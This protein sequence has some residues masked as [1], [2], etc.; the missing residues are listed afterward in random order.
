MEREQIEYYRHRAGEYDDFWTRSGQYTLASD[1][2]ARWNADAAEAVAAVRS[3]APAGDVL[4]LACGTGLW[5][6][7]LASIA[8]SL[9]AV[10]SS[11]EML[12]LNA[13]RLA[14]GG[15]AQNAVTYEQADLFT[16]SPPA[17]CFDAVFFGYWHSH[18]PDERLA[19]FWATVG[20]ALQPGGSV[21]LV[22]SAPDPAAP[23]G[24]LA[25]RDEQRSLKDGRRYRVVKRYWNP[26]HLG[27]ALWPLG[28]D[29]VA[30]TTT[31]GLILLAQLHRRR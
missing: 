18:L 31:H 7:H 5:T 27:A 28:W 26:E 24:D 11:P 25:A 4:E 19:P 29:A 16:W 6:E 8:T 12:T 9:R 10:D 30:R 20:R 21:M 2:L 17:A 15:G 22:D 13:A 3:W 14:Q 23:L 1:D